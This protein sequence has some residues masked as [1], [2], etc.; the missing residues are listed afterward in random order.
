MA[1]TGWPRLLR[2]LRRAL[3]LR[4]WGRDRASNRRI[5]SSVYPD[6]TYLVSYPRS[7][8]TWIRFMVANL[9]RPPETPV[10]FQNLARFT[11][12]VHEDLELLKKAPRPR[13]IKSHAPLEPRYPRTVYLVRDGRDVYVSYYHYRHA[14]LPE[15]MT[16]AEYLQADHWPCSWGEHVTSWIDAGLPEDRFL[17][18]RYERILQDPERELHRIA[19]FIGLNPSDIEVRKAVNNSSFHSMRWIEQT[20]G[21]PRSDRFSGQFVRSGNAGGWR[22]HFGKRE[23]EVFKAREQENQALVRLGYEPTADW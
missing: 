16:L 12:S 9:I 19:T 2:R 3:R 15:H 22:T 4:L 18:V 21:H 6:D 5:P 1:R 7:G 17:L 13:F 23:R 10:T 14:E 8:N 11:P 20:S